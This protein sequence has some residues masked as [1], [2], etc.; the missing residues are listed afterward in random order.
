MPKKTL[1]LNCLSPTPQTN[2]KLDRPIYHCLNEMLRD[3]HI[4]KALVENVAMLVGQLWEY[5]RGH[6]WV[7]QCVLKKCSAKSPSV[8][9]TVGCV[10]KTSIY[11]F[12]N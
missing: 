5:L 1:N 10:A 3:S 6:L 7:L 2:Y 12:L 11:S 9:C 8:V 4:G